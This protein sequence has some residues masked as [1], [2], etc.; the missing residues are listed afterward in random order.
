MKYIPSL[1]VAAL[2]STV[3]YAA[4]DG[5]ILMQPM[6]KGYK[7]GWQNINSERNW[8]EYVPE[9]ETVDNWTTMVTTQIFF[10]MAQTTPPEFLQGMA[11]RCG[12]ACPN[13]MLDTF[14][15]N[16]P[17]PAGMYSAQSNGYPISM[18]FLRCPENPQTHKPE[19]TLVRAIQGKDSF[20]VVQYAFKFEPT[21]PQIG[22]AMDYLKTVIACDTRTTDHPCPNLAAQGFKKIEQP[23]NAH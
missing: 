20:Y 17:K 10:K 5:E 12:V 15:P 23:P 22:E 3:A 7:L 6:L 11:H 21:Q 1:I 18:M 2:F 4:I 19:N 14:L 13:A 8:Q 16:M 9:G